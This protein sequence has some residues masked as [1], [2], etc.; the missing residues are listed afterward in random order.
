MKKIIQLVGVFLIVAVVSACSMKSMMVNER[1]S[2]YDVD[3]TVQVI[4]DNA[5]KIGWVSPGVRNMN[6]SVTKQEE[7]LAV[8]RC[9]LLSSVTQH[10]PARSFRMIPVAIRH[11]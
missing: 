10:M 7:R 4:R 1:V 11:S 2:P 5:K 3:K 9:V 8:G 6:K